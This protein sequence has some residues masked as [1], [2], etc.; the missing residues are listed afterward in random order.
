[1]TKIK[2]IFGMS[3]MYMMK[4]AICVLPN[5]LKKKQQEDRSLFQCVILFQLILLCCRVNFIFYDW[6]SRIARK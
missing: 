1:M 2:I 3:Y 5:A 6:Q 4:S